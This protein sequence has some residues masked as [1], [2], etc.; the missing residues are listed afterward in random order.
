MSN[1]GVLWKDP[2][3]T[4]KMPGGIR[5][6][7]LKSPEYNSREA[8]KHGEDVGFARSIMKFDVYA[9][10]DDDLQVKTETGAVVTIAFW[11]LMALLACGE[12]AAYLRKA[13][14]TERLVVDSTMGQKL[15]I[16]ADIVSGNPR[17]R[18][19]G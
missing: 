6:R 1:I 12:V 5:H 2:V 3:E 8:P 11:I 15:R 9:K 13:P 18:G 16:N 4:T 17:A 7:N 19:V 14:P 10:V